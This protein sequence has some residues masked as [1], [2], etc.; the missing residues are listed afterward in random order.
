[1]Q[2]IKDY[3]L[4]GMILLSLVTCRMFNPGQEEFAA[5]A[6]REFGIPSLIFPRT[7]STARTSTKPS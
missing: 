4:D 3:Q 5:R 6:E 1:M 2:L 7:W